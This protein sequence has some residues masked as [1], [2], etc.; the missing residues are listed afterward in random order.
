[1]KNYTDITVVLDRSGSMESIKDDMIGGFNAF[2]D[3]QAKTDGKATVSLIQ[4]D[5]EYDVNYSGVDIKHVKHLDTN[6]YRTRGMTAL[7]DALGRAIDSVGAR[8]AALPK[9]DRP[10]KVVI[11]VITDGGENS[12]KEYK[13][14]DVKNKIKHQQDVYKWAFVFIGAD[15]DS[16]LSAKTYEMSTNNAVNFIKSK[17]GV[18]KMWKGL[19]DAT[20][21]YRLSSCVNNMSY[22]DTNQD[23]K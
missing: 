10:E 6:T 8:L 15:Q 2:I 9:N 20:S 7:V 3:E 5:H 11:L 19:S 4:F 1:M 22:F 16:F 23:S 14:A 18:D 17:D 12:S 13:A 21:N